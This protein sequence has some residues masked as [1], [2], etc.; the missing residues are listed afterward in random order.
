MTKGLPDTCVRQLRAWASKNRNA[1]QLWLFGSRAD[2]T[3]RPESDVDL[4]LGLMPPD[5]AHNWAL[6]NFEFLKVEWQRE[7]EAIVGCHVSLEAITPDEPGS[8]RVQNWVLLWE[9]KN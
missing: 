6:G 8:S 1:R 5:G 2:G 7:L 3:A 9:R 4:A